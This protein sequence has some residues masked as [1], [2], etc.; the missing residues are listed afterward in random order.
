MLIHIQPPL[1][2][3]WAAKKFLFFVLFCLDSLGYNDL[4]AQPNFRITN[5]TV[6]EGLSEASVH[7]MIKDVHG[8]L[9]IATDY[10]IN[11]FDG[12]TF[13]QYVHQPGLDQ[14]FHGSEIIGLV[15]DSLH[16]IWVGT[17]EGL[18]RYVITADSFQ[19]IPTIRPDKNMSSY[20]M[21]LAA[22][23]DEVIIWEITN[24]IVAYNIHTLKRKVLFSAILWPATRI[25]FLNHA[26]FNDVSKVIWVPNGN[27]ILQISLQAKRID[28]IFLPA[29]AGDCQAILEDGAT[30][31]VA[32]SAG[33]YRAL[34]HEKK[35]ESVSWAAPLVKYRIFSLAKNKSGNFWVG[36]EK[37]GLYLYDKV[38]KKLYNYRAKTT[39]LNSLSSNIINHLYCDD[40]GITW[41]ASG[42]KSIDQVFTSQQPFEC[43]SMNIAKSVNNNSVRCFEEDEKHNI[44]IGTRGG[45]INIFDPGQKTFRYITKSKTPLL[46]SNNVQ[47][48]KIGRDRRRIWIGTD[49]GLL[50]METGN[51]KAR[52]VSFTSADG[53]R[54]VSPVLVHY[55]ILIHDS[56]LLV[57][58]SKGVFYLSDNSLD[59]RQLPQ[60]KEHTF[61]IGKA[62]NKFTFSLWDYDPVM[63][64]YSRGNWVKK[65]FP[66]EDITVSCLFFDRARNIFWIGTDRGVLITDTS[67]KRL[68][69]L[70]KNEGLPDNCIWGL[71]PDLHGNLWITTNKGIACYN[72]LSGLIK[73]Y[74]PEDGI[75]G[76]EYNSFAYFL[77]SDSSVYLGGKSGFDHIKPALI[78]NNVPPVNVHVS[79]FKIQGKDYTNIVSANYLSNVSL[80]HGQNNI[81][82]EVASIDFYS[83]GRS[84]LRYK[85]LPAE[86]DWQMAQAPF[87]IRY[88]GLSPGNYVLHVS[89]ADAYGR[90]N[91]IEKTLSI[92]ISPPFWQRWWFVTLMAL[93]LIAGLYSLYRYRLKQIKEVFAVRTKISQDLHDEVGATLS[94]ISLYSHLTREQVRTNQTTEVEKSLSVIQQSASDMVSRLSDIVWVVN[95]QHD[96]LQKLLQKLEEVGTDMAMTSNIKMQVNV[97]PGIAALKLPMEDRHS[98]YLICK[99]AIN[100]AVKYSQATELALSVNAVDHSVQFL[101][102]DNGKG[103]DISKVKKG[104]GLDNMQKRADEIGANLTFQSTLNEGALVS[105]Q[106]KITQ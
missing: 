19:H 87:T 27:M 12:T 7:K 83:S 95:P 90:W 60:I 92:I 104:N 30:L 89:A 6:K 32:S 5:W 93:L 28:S 91:G 105:L 85:L 81:S 16:N 20:C 2:V 53:T 31:L 106:Y 23:K 94:G 56:A 52:S 11:R 13:T 49:V 86:S 72:T 64:E 75:Q 9:W 77:A 96:S 63:Y 41:V 78:N 24:N 65:H 58:T 74:I 99:E 8:F 88:S 80:K 37:D 42:N 59:A 54:I 29:E 66:F 79:S 18:N 21:P 84:K 50:Q 98:I 55:M 26:V 38:D 100:N 3:K 4:Y 25:F 57:A 68:R 51:Q 97:E 34:V 33:L 82:I 45:G 70:S 103:F 76:L 101:V 46:G 71:L 40:T 62:N 39:R 35:T 15:E 43:F 22:T 102:K 14:G 73:N 17:E 36:T 61:F 67:F 10:G 1:Y 47:A 44:W 69:N 48:L